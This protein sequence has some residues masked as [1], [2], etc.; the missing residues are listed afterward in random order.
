M[1]RSHA[2]LSGLFDYAGLYPPAA[3]PLGEAMANYARYRTGRQGWMLGRFIVP[4]QRLEECSAIG[5]R[6]F[7]KGAGAASWRISALAGTEPES[8]A[9]QVSAFNRRHAEPAHGAAIV[10][11]LETRVASPQDVR[12]VRTWASR[13]FDV[14]CE[15]AAGPDMERLLDAIARAGLHAKVR[16]GGVT[17]DAIPCRDHVAAFL[18]ACAARGVVAKATA[19]LHHALTGEYPLTYA[20]DA[21]RASMF[22]YLNL[23]LAAGIAEGAGRSAAQSIEVRAT[24]ARLLS[25]EVP[26]AWIGHGAME[27]SGKNGPI[28]E[29][30]LDHF[31]VSG[32]A[33]IRS[34]GTC[35]FEEPVEQAR[36]IGLIV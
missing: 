21:P 28:I 34:V 24:V 22:G 27:W 26:P 12:A 4:A 10:D 25:L 18:C 36:S 7:P 23:V 16:T 31:A 11:T 32:R 17:A 1:P 3:L 35:A 14:Y 8:D 2:L 19:G 33:L 5:A 9:S 13:G 20:P 15:V 29:G 30:P 6:L